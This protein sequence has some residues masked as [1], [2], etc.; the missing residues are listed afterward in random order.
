MYSLSL[1]VTAGISLPYNIYGAMAGQSVFTFRS[2]FRPPYYSFGGSISESASRGLF[3]R[4]KDVQVNG[5]REVRLDDGAGHLRGFR[6][7]SVGI[8]HSRES[9][10]R[11]C[12]TWRLLKGGLLNTLFERPVIPRRKPFSSIPYCTCAGVPHYTF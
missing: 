12:L 3:S 6:K 1:F 5:G 2:P 9:S 4:A 10:C 8:I 11:A 7:Y